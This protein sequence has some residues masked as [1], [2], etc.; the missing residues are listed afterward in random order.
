L[1]TACSNI[2]GNQVIETGF[3]YGDLAVVELVNLGSLVSKEFDS[4]GNTREKINNKK[5][6]IYSLSRRERGC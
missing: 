3:V 5:I 1:Q 6:L 4:H 2:A